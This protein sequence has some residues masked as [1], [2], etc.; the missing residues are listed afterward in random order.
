ME[1]ETI[2]AIKEK[3][4]LLPVSEEIA[5]KAVAVSVENGLPMADA[6]IYATSSVNKMKLVSLDNDF[7]V[8]E[9]AEVLKI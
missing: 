8:L 6:L 9:N 3:S 2:R 1:N 4:I 7:R 5:E